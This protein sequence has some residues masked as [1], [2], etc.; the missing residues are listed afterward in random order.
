[1]AGEIGP[2]P[3]NAGWVALQNRLAAAFVTFLAVASRLDPAARERAGVCGV[4]SPKDMVAHLIGWDFEAARR[5][6]AFVAG[7]TVDITYD[8][9]AFNAGSVVAR[10]YLSWE[11]ILAELQAARQ[12]LQE[13]IAA[14]TDDDVA[15]EP[16]IAAWVA[17]RSDDY[18]EHTAQLRQWEYENV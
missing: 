13:A 10:Q 3:V 18:E 12:T 15:R 2:E 17:G 8:L 1:M 6:R 11:Q 7:P 9:D 16:R 4:W 5:L 14:V